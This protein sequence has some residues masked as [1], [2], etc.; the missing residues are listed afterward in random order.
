MTNL[1]IN[2]NYILTSP[3]YKTFVCFESTSSVESDHDIESDHDM[4]SSYFLFLSSPLI[5]YAA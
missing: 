5:S 2:H 3:V 4:E 1:F